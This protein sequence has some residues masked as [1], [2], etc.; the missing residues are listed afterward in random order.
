M[1]KYNVLT[2]NT[3][4]DEPSFVNDKAKWWFVDSLGHF[5][6]YLV[7]TNDEMFSYVVVDNI[8]N[9]I[10][11][12]TQSLEAASRKMGLLDKAEKFL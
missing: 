2:L 10:V 1:K 5:N 12:A 6:M 9:N 7:K 8:T 4:K 3:E 11:C